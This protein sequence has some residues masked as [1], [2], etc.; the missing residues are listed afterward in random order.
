MKSEKIMKELVSIGL[1]KQVMCSDSETAKF[2]ESGTSDL[3]EGVFY[4]MVS[5]SDDDAIVKL[6][7]TFWRYDIS[8][9]PEPELHTMLLAKMV[10]EH[11]ELTPKINSIK[12]WVAVMGGLTVVNIVLAIIAAFGLFL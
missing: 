3:P 11:Q 9:L 4:D 5:K 6:G 8:E 7:R 10:K 2:R 1:A 12:T